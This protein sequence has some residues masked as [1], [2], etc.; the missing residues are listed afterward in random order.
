MLGVTS[1]F[2]LPSQK[3]KI[4]K[5]CLWKNP[6][7]TSEKPHSVFLRTYIMQSGERF[8][9]DLNASEDVTL[10][11]R[12]VC[13]SPPLPRFKLLCTVTTT[14]F[15]YAFLKLNTAKQSYRRDF[16]NMPEISLVWTKGFPQLVQY[17][18]VAC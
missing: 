10:S 13:G 17:F 1:E 8:L 7:P 11:A 4:E 14:G 5:I 12:V 2:L 18:T 3:R 16:Q 15:Y 9:C 6:K